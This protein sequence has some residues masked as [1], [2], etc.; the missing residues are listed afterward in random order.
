MQGPSVKAGDPA[1][2]I[3]PRAM[4]E[5]ANQMKLGGA[6]GWTYTVKVSFIQIYLETV[7][8]LLRERDEDVKHE[9]KKVGNHVVVTDVNMVTLDPS[10]TSQI[11]KIMN[12]AAR[13]RPARTPSPLAPTLFLPCIYTVRIR[14]R[15][16]N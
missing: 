5:I 13:M 16:R 6:L 2:G 8:D 15:V 3:I 11:T 14:L 9:I 1:R 10:D 12:K 7:Q 4:E